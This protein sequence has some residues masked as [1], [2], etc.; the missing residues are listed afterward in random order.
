VAVESELEGRL[1]PSF[2]ALLYDV[3]SVHA[4]DV[5]AGRRFLA[6]IVA[7]QTARDFAPALM[8]LLVRL[9]KHAPLDPQWREFFES[10]LRYL[11]QALEPVQ[12]PLLLQEIRRQH[13]HEGEDRYMTIADSLRAEGMQ[14]GL[15]QG[16][17]QGALRSK[18]QVLTRLIGRKYDITPEERARIE[19]TTDAEALD[20]ALA[21][22][23]D[24]ESKHAVL[25][26]LG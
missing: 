2:R 5:V 4:E 3:G 6:T 15:Q 23:V 12:H 1:V 11:L 26:K 10:V 22:I 8:R 20:R 13:F 17:R 19:S 14:Q 18:Q 25:R 7:L 24:G 9:L 16:L 21:A